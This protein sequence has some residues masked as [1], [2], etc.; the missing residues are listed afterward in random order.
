MAWLM[1]K[2]ASGKER[3]HELLDDLTFIGSAQECE[4]RV[5]DAAP[6]HCQIVKAGAG[7]KLIDLGSP[8]GT[9]VNGQKVKDKA[10][11][12]GDVVEVGATA[13]TFKAGGSTAA[14][15]K[16]AAVPAARPAAPAARPAA[17]A[18]ARPAAAPV[19]RA[20]AP[21]ARRPSRATAARG[22]RRGRDDSDDEGEEEA[23]SARAERKLARSG[24]NP[25]I[26]VG[27]SVVSLA[28]LIAVAVNVMGGDDLQE[29]IRKAEAA[30][31]A[32]NPDVALA[33][34]EAVLKVA[35]PGSYDA[36]QAQV[37]KDR[38][39]LQKKTNVGQH[40]E[41][42]ED[43][44]FFSNLKPFYEMYIDDKSPK[45]KGKDYL[46]DPA[47]ARYFVEYR[48][49]YY[50]KRFPNGANVGTVRAWEESLKRRFNP[51]D[52]F[53]RPDVWWDTEVIATFESKLEH[54]GIAWKLR[55]EFRDR[56]PNAKNMRDVE[57]EVADELG[58]A[59]NYANA[60][61]KENERILEGATEKLAK[62]DKSGLSTA[63]GKALSNSIKACNNL[64]GMPDLIERVRGVGQK[65]VD[66]AKS[67]GF[68][69]NSADVDK[70]RTAGNGLEG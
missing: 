54:Y 53:P 69:F 31:A 56:N 45:F 55:S 59:Q 2:L 18:A 41:R 29:G 6:K 37:V 9:R 38:I 48:V 67:A 44:Y 13:L 65:A 47:T 17:A 39:L 32:N 70:L 34:I 12:D 57:R 68:P 4:I 60:F 63:F 51:A 49:A 43:A 26:T 40:D 5:A 28:I 14:A 50:L 16:A 35:R 33:E 42:Q 23:S 27:I 62:G 19:A 36:T 30:I 15:A 7:L 52:P 20:P 66:M 46:N 24:R 22:G 1:V 64:R 61:M 25:M 10:L 11:L 8:A 58:R 3:G 21:A